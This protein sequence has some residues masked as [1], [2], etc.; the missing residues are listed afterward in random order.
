MSVHENSH[1]LD[2]NFTLIV[3]Q[4]SQNQCFCTVKARDSQPDNIPRDSQM[5]EWCVVDCLTNALDII[6]LACIAGQ[7]KDTSQHAIDHLICRD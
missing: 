5:W 2:A 1:N 7:G 3:Y 4:T 6:S